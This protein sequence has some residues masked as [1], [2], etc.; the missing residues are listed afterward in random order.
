MNAFVL[1]D[2]ADMSFSKESYSSKETVWVDI[3][4][5]EIPSEDLVKSMF[6]VY[7]SEGGKLSIV[8]DLV[9]VTDD[10]YYFYF[11]VPEVE[12]GSL[13]LEIKDVYFVQG[14]SLVKKIYNGTFLVQNQDVVLSFWPGVSYSTFSVY[15][16]SFNIEFKNQGLDKLDIV[17]NTSEGLN[18]PAFDE[19]KLVSGSSRIIT[20]DSSVDPSMNFLLGEVFVN[21]GGAD[22]IIPIILSKVGYTG[23]FTEEVETNNTVDGGENVSVVEPDV[24]SLPDIGQNDLQFI[25]PTYKEIYESFNS[26]DLEP[27]SQI[28][29]LKNLGGVDFHDISFDI[30]D[31]LKSIMEYEIVEGEDYLSTIPSNE[32]IEI[33]IIVFPD[34]AELQHYEGSFVVNSA[35]GIGDV[36]TFSLN[37]DVEDFQQNSGS[38][39]TQTTNGSVTY[40]N[41][42]PIDNDVE[43]PN[44][45]GW[46]ILVSIILC[47]IGI[48]V[49]AYIKSKPKQRKFEK[50]LESIKN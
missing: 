43:D 42:V 5:D 48:V 15:A 38:N 50:Y 30:S 13:M 6:S 24:V 34:K 21:Y 10:W 19:F 2:S 29:K 17:L 1:A 14:E 16:P 47:L 31:S 12:N 44:F 49:F 39:Y 8:K 46:V 41:P 45:W 28:W 22:L 27:K 11:K 4:L 36:L 25:I 3:K 40:N 9:K 35:E 37:F 26:I 32:Q 7:D 20:V 23:D 33:E 18:I